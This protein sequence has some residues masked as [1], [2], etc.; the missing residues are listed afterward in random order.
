M[1]TPKFWRQWHRWV[2]FVAALFL[3]FAGATGTIVAFTE[4]FGEEEALREATRDLVSPVATSSA[5]EVWRDPIAR[6]MATAAQKAPGAPIDRITVQFKGKQPTV[7]L[8]TGKPK[9]G[10]DQKL[11]FD[12]TTGSLVSEEAY[13]DKALINRIHSGEFFG[14]GGLVFGMLWGLSLVAMTISGLLI[15]F[16]MRR[17][18]AV[19][20]KRV[21]W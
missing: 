8:F 18:G 19:G 1:P 11:V 10:E 6:A 20:I 17:D 3:I 2:G 14:D 12:A 21:F 13:A 4:F 5:P 15:Y 16:R 7:T 9:G